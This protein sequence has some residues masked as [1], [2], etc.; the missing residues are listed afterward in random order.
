MNITR[1][2]SLMLLP[3]IFLAGCATTGAG[4]GAND[5]E[6]PPLPPLEKMPRVTVQQ[7]PGLAV[8]TLRLVGA[9]EGG[10]LVLVNSLG[11]RVLPELNL[12]NAPY[13]EFVQAVATGLQSSSAQVDG[14]YFVYPPGYDQLMQ[15]DITPQLPAA[16]SDIRGDFSFG[17]GTRLYN[18]FALLNQ[19]LGINLVADQSVA[20]AA[21]GEMT[22]VDMPLPVALNA[23][24]RGARVAPGSIVVEAREEYVL[25]RS[26]PNAH[27]DSLLKSA[28]GLSPEARKLLDTIVDVFLPAPMKRGQGPQVLNTARPLRLA[29]RSL[30]QQL[31]I[32]VTADPAMLD[33]PVNNAYLSDISIGGVM[34][35]LIR[36]WLVQDFG[37]E[38][39]DAGIAL[40]RR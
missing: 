16:Y 13:E 7:S 18:V 23:I 38:V 21:C 8:D 11:T 9:E 28:E 34:D 29:V 32:P 3:M 39:T 1:L 19:T 31:G 14:Y 6:T 30:S 40:G 27:P 37:Y 4:G 22:L 2:K 26:L 17:E 36:Q 35:A 20:D 15:L 10:A 33:L 24:L 5:A 25:F 12:E